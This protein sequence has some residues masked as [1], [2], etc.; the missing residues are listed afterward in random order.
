MAAPINQVAASEVGGAR[1]GCKGLS[2]SGWLRSTGVAVLSAL[3]G[4]AAAVAAQRS[5]GETGFL[6]TV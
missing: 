1:G 6:A 2:M 3:L 4:V 5:Y